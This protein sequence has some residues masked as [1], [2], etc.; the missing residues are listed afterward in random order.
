MLFEDVDEVHSQYSWM[1]HHL[2]ES[3]P[4]IVKFWVKERHCAC[5]RDLRNV[6]F[7]TASALYVFCFISISSPQ[8]ENSQLCYEGLKNYSP[9]CRAFGSKRMRFVMQK[10]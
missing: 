9:S 7:S 6:S 5:D 3:V 8:E 10:S 2:E 1:S 4:V